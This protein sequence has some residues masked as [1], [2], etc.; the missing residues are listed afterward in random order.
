MDNLQYFISTKDTA[1]FLGFK[2]YYKWI[3]FNTED[4]RRNPSLDNQSFKPYYKWI[5][6]NT[7]YEL[8]CIH[9]AC[10]F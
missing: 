5:T 6:F 8:V 10:T 2:P 3:T 4:K 9:N 1:D 7:L